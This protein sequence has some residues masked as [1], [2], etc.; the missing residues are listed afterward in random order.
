MKE[1]GRERGWRICG[2]KVSPGH[3]IFIMLMNS[4]QV[5][6]PPKTSTILGVSIFHL[7]GW[8]GS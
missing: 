6:I 1:E 2:K 8:K 4:L 5:W 3:D 7:G